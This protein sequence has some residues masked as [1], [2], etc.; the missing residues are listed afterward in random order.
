[1]DPLW[2]AVAFILGFAVKQVGLPSLIGFLAAG[3]VLQAF[4]VESTT[5]LKTIAD[6][7]VL[8]LLFTIG[9]KLRVKNLLKPQVWAVASVHMAVTIVIFTTTIF[10]LGGW[11]GWLFNSMDFSAAILVA[12]ALSFSSTVFAVKVLEEKGEMGALHGRVAIGILIMQDIFA[13]VFIT[14]SSGKLPS[15]WAAALFGLLLIRPVLIF[16]MKRAGHGELLILL[17]LL[18]PIAG[19]ALFNAVG[20]KPDLGALAMGAL[21]AGHLKADELA[22]TLLGFKDIFLMGFFLN[23]GL[24]GFPDLVSLAVTALFVL[25]LPVKTALFFTLFTRFKLRARTSTLASLSL[26]NYSEFG[27][28]VG[29]VGVANGFIGS[30]WLVVFAVALSISFILAA[31]LNTTAHDIYAR[32]RPW[33][34]KFESKKRLPEDEIIS[35]GKADILV[36]GMG[37]VVSGAYDFLRNRFGETVLGIDFDEE[38]VADHQR[39]GRRVFQGDAT[40]YDFW[41]RLRS[42]GTVRLVLLTMPDY[43][44][45]K[46]AAERIAAFSPD[47]MIAAI[48]KHDDEAAVLKAAGAHEVFNF[49]AETGVGFAEHV[50]MH[51]PSLLPQQ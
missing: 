1:M 50:C 2:L 15:P 29:A 44:A 16:L 9:L 3:F 49:Y 10:V 5:T 45:N 4:G 30:Q 51:L 12:F 35:I 13:V 7:G 27:L 11:G 19:G 34:Q 17:G 14:A 46:Y 48:A 25:I 32:W 40:D 37:G 8:L 23:I 6:Y 24:V 28:I 43:M 21:L 39:A 22:K 20:L 31:P 38:V 33:L 42:D 36:F 18:L 26:S 41:E 47:T